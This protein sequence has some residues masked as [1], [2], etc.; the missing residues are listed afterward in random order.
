MD[1]AVLYSGG[2]DS[3]Y[4]V[5][6]ALEK[7]WR[8]KYLLSVKPTRNDCYL[9]HYATVEH[10]PLLAE[11]LGLKHYLLSCDVANPSEEAAI[12]R[13]FVE[14]HRV[15]AVVLGGTG[16][17][18]TQIRSIQ[19]ALLPLRVEAFASHAGMDH[20]LLVEEMIRKGYKFMITQIASE[21]LGEGWL[22]KVLDNSS[23]EELKRLSMNH[24][25]HVGGEGGYYDTFVLE[26]P[27]FKKK[28]MVESLKKEMESD[29]VG[30]VVFE[31]L[32]VLDKGVIKDAVQ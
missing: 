15:D 29:C 31:K 19:E 27:V 4:A 7:G 2:K 23:F 24:G 9:F 10:T 22:G 12:V 25:F 28:V 11:L 32:K 17:Q 6:W 1:V 30:H 13:R 8:V 26:A 3:T 14:E 21:G 5:A 20:D 16:L 18:E